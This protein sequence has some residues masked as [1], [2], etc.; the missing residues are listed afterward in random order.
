MLKTIVLIGMMGSGKTSVGKELAKN[1]NLN[2]IDS[3]QEIEKK[4]K[5][6]IPS[7]FEK[8][9]EDYFRKIEEKI[10]CKLIDGK[11]KILSLGGGAFINSKFR[12]EIKKN[13]VSFW[14]STNLENIYDRLLQSKNKRPMLDYN[15]LK[16]SIKDIYD[17]RK[18]IYKKA[19]YTIRT[20]SDNKKNIVNK[21]IENL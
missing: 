7:I 13:G 11:P 6:S 5:I 3:D 10:C 8:K 4:C 12:K 1:L 2:F 19:D 15:N 14:I 21:I 16:K 17:S 20:K 18:E 9:G